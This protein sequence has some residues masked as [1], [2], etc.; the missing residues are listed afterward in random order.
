[1]PK[2]L[3]Y[4]A[5]VQFES[6]LFCLFISLDNMSEESYNPNWGLHYFSK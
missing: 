3:I 4:L 2:L 1:M 5:F 6:R